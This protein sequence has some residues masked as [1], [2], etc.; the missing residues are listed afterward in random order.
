MVDFPLSEDVDR[1]LSEYR[2]KGMFDSAITAMGLH[3]E[4][5]SE[6]DKTLAALTYINECL[7]GVPDAVYLNESTISRTDVEKEAEGHLKVGYP[8]R[9]AKLSTKAPIDYANFEESPK[10]IKYKVQSLLACDAILAADSK[11]RDDR[12]YKPGLKFV[13][14]WVSNYIVGKREDDYSWYDMAVGQ[15]GTKL[16]YIL[17]RAIEKEESYKFMAPMIVASD[18]HIRDLMD[19]DKLALHSN[20]GLFQM[21]GL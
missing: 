2:K 11:K 19:K 15:R 20:H 10:N 14:D 8:V 18:I 12:W 3:L 4:G 9:G 21:L 6:E 5:A 7:A 17:R 1:L 16:S 13:R